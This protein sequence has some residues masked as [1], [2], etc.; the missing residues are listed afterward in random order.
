K[1][2]VALD[3]PFFDWLEQNIE[4]LLARERSTLA[5]AVRRSCE[6][7]AAI[8]ATDE[9]EAGPR[10]LLNL[11]HTFGHAIETATGFGSWLHGEAVAAGM[12]MAAELSTRIGLLE[13]PDAE[14]IARLIAR[15][16]LPTRPP[17]LARSQWHELMSIDKKSA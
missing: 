11:G 8:V 9:R 13:R 3:A 12:V 16:G 7:K 1:H 15:A 6:L 5:Y 2:G 14:R 17:A 4:P 10:A